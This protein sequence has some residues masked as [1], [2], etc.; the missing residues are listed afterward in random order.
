MFSQK[1]VFITGIAGFIGFHVAQALIRRNDRVIGLDNFNSYY[2]PELKKKRVALLS[3]QGIEVIT[4]DL[5]DQKKLHSV[6]EQYSFTHILHLAAQAGVRHARK[7][8]EAYL[9]NN[10]DGFLSILELLRQYRHV[11][12]IYASS[13]SIYGLNESIPFSILDPTDKPANLY[14]VTK[15]TNELMA[16]SYHH[17]YDIKT[18]ALRYFTVYGPWGR[19]DMAYFLFTKA[20][21][22]RKPI[23]LFNQG[24][25]RRDFTYIDDAVEGTLA[26]ID[27]K[28]VHE[29]FNI[30]NSQPVELLNFVSILE[31]ILNIKA[32][33]EFKGPSPGEIDTSYADI[34]ESQDKLGFKPK[35]NL[36]EGL[37]R[38]V[39]WYRQFHK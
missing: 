6:F 4:A 3:E 1:T 2:S 13:S 38:F 17:L 24:L 28:G 35:I 12:L 19:P 25:M 7:Q 27:Y 23:I 18:T 9:K 39:E 8:P 37:R 16:Y 5:N 20:I 21:D 36:E 10:I 32:I 26:A 34:T 22:E 30:G 33:K 29:R 14:A 15:K 11:N 31:K